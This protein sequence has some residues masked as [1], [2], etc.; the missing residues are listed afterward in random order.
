LITG[1]LLA[2]AL[3]VRHA[4]EPDHIVA[5]STL[6]AG[7]PNARRAATLGAIWGVGHSAAL[8]GVGGLLMILHW[9]LPD[10][11]ADLFEL[12][13][14]LMLLVLGVRSIASALQLRAA[15]LVHVRAAH[16]GRL[17]PPG[18]HA[19]GGRAPHHHHARQNTQRPL[20]IGLVHGL[21]GSGALTALALANMP[22]IGSGLAYIAFFGLGSVVGMALLAGLIGLPAAQFASRSRFQVVALAA[23]GALSFAVGLAWA[24]P[25]LLR[26][27]TG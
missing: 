26:V 27:G 24:W 5:V 16:G 10:R 25:L 1:W 22:S 13:V 23:T 17:A 7:A 14:A 3:G 19:H 15:E 12:G 20:V 2:L 11:L 21:A 4:S 18:L 9:R 6:V 8:L